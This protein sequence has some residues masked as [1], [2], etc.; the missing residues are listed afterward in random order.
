[1]LSKWSSVYEPSWV[2]ILITKQASLRK[3]MWQCSCDPWY[4]IW[5]RYKALIGQYES[6]LH[7]V[8]K[9]EV[10]EE[11]EVYEAPGGRTEPGDKCH[12]L[13]WDRRECDR[14]LTYWSNYSCS[15]HREIAKPETQAQG[16]R[17]LSFIKAALERPRCSD[18]RWLESSSSYNDW[19]NPMAARASCEPDNMEGSLP[20]GDEGKIQSLRYAWAGTSSPLNERDKL[21]LAS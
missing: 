1:M 5:G 19:A 15:G 4:C 2:S 18:N 12:T 14:M 16:R 9:L 17:I 3:G 11:A 7:Q 8:N 13:E 10:C 6:F 20:T 21:G